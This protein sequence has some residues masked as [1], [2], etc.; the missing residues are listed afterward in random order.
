MARM[1]ELSRSELPFYSRLQQEGERNQPSQPREPLLHN[2]DNRK[3]LRR[4][5]VSLFAVLVIAF[6]LWSFDPPAG[7]TPEP[8]PENTRTELKFVA[9]VHRHG[10]RSALHHYDFEQK[11]EFSWDVPPGK[12]LDVGFKNAF[13][14][15]QS[16]RQNYS[17]NTGL[18]DERSIKAFSTN[19]DRTID[20]VH[21]VL[22]GILSPNNTEVSEG[23]CSC[24]PEDKR[25]STA[26]C[27]AQCIGVEKPS[28]LPQVE[29]WDKSSNKD[30]ILRQ[31]ELCKGWDKFREELRKSEEF[32]KA[33]DITFKED[34]EYVANITQDI[35]V[36]DTDLNK[37]FHIDLEILTKIWDTNKCLI[38]QNKSTENGP[39]ED[40]TEVVNRLDNATLFVWH[41]AYSTEVGPKIGGIFLGEIIKELQDRAERPVTSQEEQ[42]KDNVSGK[43]PFMKIYSAHDST[44]ASLLAAM[45]YGSWH[46]PQFLS[47]IVFELYGPPDKIEGTLYNHYLRVF[48]DNEILKLGNCEYSFCELHDFITSLK[49]RSKT[50]DDCNRH[51]EHD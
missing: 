39:Y 51:K 35:T 26:E 42:S 40:P 23:D 11:R 43:S 36:F 44:L 30:V 41:H 34:I 45:N 31:Y 16:L 28:S 4:C 38:A 6:V 7:S 1:M 49:E 9:L 25:N 18:I 19:V 27:V 47:H 46:F 33:N 2:L 21:G 10:A 20:T 14:F 32:K 48:Y 17:N 15:G 13:K 24:R 50:T 29:I 22:I 3:L 5:G 37:T 8:N 12:L